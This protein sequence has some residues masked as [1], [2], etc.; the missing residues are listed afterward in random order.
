[1]TLGGRE[2]GDRENSGTESSTDGTAWG[3]AC[4]QELVS[5]GEREAVSSRPL[6]PSVHCSYDKD[7]KGKR[8]KFLS[9]N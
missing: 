1:M 6:V 5:S 9:E 4:G 2:A 7:K 3:L 8:S